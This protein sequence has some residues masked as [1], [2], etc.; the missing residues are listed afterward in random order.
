MKSL[1]IHLQVQL[2]T[3]FSDTDLLIL[4]CVLL[5]PAKFVG[6]LKKIT[7]CCWKV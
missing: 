6:K 1:C 2:D 5:T 7:E 3:H 4:F